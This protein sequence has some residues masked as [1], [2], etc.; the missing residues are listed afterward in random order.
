MPNYVGISCLTL[1][2][3]LNKLIPLNEEAPL[4]SFKV[5]FN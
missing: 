4:H 5:L 1:G 3:S 2:E